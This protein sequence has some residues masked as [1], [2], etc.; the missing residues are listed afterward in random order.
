MTTHVERFIQQLDDSTGPSYDGRTELID[1]GSDA[2]PPS[3]TGC[4]PSAAAVS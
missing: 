4:L 2:V 3:S 1:I